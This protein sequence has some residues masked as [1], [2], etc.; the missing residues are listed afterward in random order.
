MG[1]GAQ[2]NF[3]EQR[4]NNFNEIIPELPHHFSSDY[5]EKEGPDTPVIRPLQPTV[6]SEEEETAP[7]AIG[8]KTTEQSADN[9]PAS[10]ETDANDS[11]SPPTDD[12]GPR[13]RSAPVRWADESI[14]GIY[15]GIATDPDELVEPQTY[16][17]AIC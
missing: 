10:T 7:G 2:K 11:L 3:C 14:T 13:K 4:R 15:A 5:S 16:E 12:L 1:L 8:V 9:R 6:P 17:E